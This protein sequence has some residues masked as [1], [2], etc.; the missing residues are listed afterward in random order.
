DPRPAALRV[1][2]DDARRRAAFLRR[3]GDRATDRPARALQAEPAA[4]APHRRQGL[5]ALDPLATAAHAPRLVERRRWRSGRP[6]HTAR[7]PPPRR[8]SRRAV[9]LSG[10]A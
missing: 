5:A 4:P 3:R 6:F 9:R 2:R 8:L 10:S 1:A 7:L